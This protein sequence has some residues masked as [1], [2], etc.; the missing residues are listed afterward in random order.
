MHF[1]QVDVRVAGGSYQFT[2]DIEMN[3]WDTFAPVSVINQLVSLTLSPWLCSGSHE[4]VPENQECPGELPSVVPLLLLW[5]SKL[6]SGALPSGLGF[7]GS[8]WRD[9][10]AHR[11]GQLGFQAL[12]AEDN[13]GTG[14]AP[15]GLFWDF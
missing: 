14:K 6:L 13:P 3:A 9:R 12:M 11:A 2:K 10:P 15:G 7:P 4:N 8:A 5:V 1:L